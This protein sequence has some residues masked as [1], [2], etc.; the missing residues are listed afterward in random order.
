M[1]KRDLL[2]RIEALERRVAQLEAQT[3]AQRTGP[4]V[5]PWPVETP[6]MPHRPAPQIASDPETM[7]MVN[8]L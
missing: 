5:E 1:R 8:I 6:V 2:A 7:I 3:G 4:Y